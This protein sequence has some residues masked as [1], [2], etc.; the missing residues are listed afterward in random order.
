[1]EKKGRKVN[2]DYTGKKNWV[3]LNN[4]PTNDHPHWALDHP[5]D[6]P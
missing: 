3:R 2:L 1:M 5:I 6:T 4:L